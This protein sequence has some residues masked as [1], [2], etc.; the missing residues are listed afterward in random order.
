MK[1]KLHNQR[2]WSV[3][4]IRNTWKVIIAILILLYYMIY[5]SLMSKVQYCAIGD[6]TPVILI[7]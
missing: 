6:W 1:F 4:M 7:T 2:L 3:I 5:P